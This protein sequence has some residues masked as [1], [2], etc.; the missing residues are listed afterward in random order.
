MIRQVIEMSKR[1]EEERLNKIEVQE[2]HQLKT[3]EL[4]SIAVAAKVNK[5]PEIKA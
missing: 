4:A 2:K 3:A 5:A 1:E